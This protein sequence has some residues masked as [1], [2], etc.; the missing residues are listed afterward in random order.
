MSNVESYAP[1]CKHC[2][3]TKSSHS[4]G[5]CLWMPTFFEAQPCIECGAELRFF[6]RPFEPLDNEEE[7]SLHPTPCYGKYRER[8]DRSVHL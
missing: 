3:M 7:Y 2:R 6:L 4:R 1:F 8:K 5:K